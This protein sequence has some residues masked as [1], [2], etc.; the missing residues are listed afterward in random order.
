MVRQRLATARRAVQGTSTGVE[1]MGRAPRAGARAR[2]VARVPLHSTSPADPV[3][4]V[5]FDVGDT[6]LDEGKGWFSDDPLLP[7]V[8]RTL[9]EIQP[10]YRMAIL[11]NTREA[12][13]SDIAQE[14]SRLGIA[15]HFQAIVTSTDIGWRK[16]HPLAFEAVLSALGLP[17]GRTV[18]VGNELDNDVA[19]AKAMGMRTVHL[20]WSPR[21]RQEP[22]AEEERATVTI[23][24]FNDLPV[25]LERVR[26]ER[27][28]RRT[29][30]IVEASLFQEGL[31]EK[32]EEKHGL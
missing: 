18:M 4:G 3:E 32:E 22:T 17:P 7:G 10:Q 21:Y 16:P 2:R 23:E 24:E 20:R 28:P 31:P 25:A 11:S 12:T 29:A 6:L 30:V 5:I 1:P 15:Q 9:G 14:L 27:S 26:G 13:R 8:R 19:G